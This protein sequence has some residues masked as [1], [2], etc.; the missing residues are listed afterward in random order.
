M[1]LLNKTK[2]IFCDID[3]VLVEHK[4]DL[5]NTIKQDPKLLDGT[6]DKLIEWDKRGYKII[7]VTGRRESMRVITEKQLSEL[8]IFYDLLIMGLGGGA[9]I[10][11]N[12]K[13]PY[14]EEDTC[15]A[16]N[17]K[18]NKGIGDIEL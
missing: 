14:S 10:V 12:D 5:S 11:I 13:K 9:R 15:Y 3:G 4:G 6:V 2:T 8:G 16:I 7:L 17:I 18:R 1:T